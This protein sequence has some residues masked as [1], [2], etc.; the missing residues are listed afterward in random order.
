MKFQNPDIID[1]YLYFILLVSLTAAVGAVLELMRQNW[2]YSRITTFFAVY[3]KHI[4][5]CE[6][7]FE[8][9]WNELENSVDVGV[10]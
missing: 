9:W 5:L 3:A 1:Y 8:W 7:G 10:E 2:V 6:N 4:S